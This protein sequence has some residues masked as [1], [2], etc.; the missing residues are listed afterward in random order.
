MQDSNFRRKT[1]ELGKQMAVIAIVT[2]IIVFAF[3]ILVQG[4]GIPGYTAG[5]NCYTG[6]NYS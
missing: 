2:S 6:F 5:Y 4:N 3:R 1:G